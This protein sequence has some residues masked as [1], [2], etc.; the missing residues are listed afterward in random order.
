MKLKQKRI[1]VLDLRISVCIYD[2]KMESNYL[3]FK[4]Y[5]F[6]LFRFKVSSIYQSNIIIQP[7]Y[8]TSFHWLLLIHSLQ[9][10]S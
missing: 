2:N 1:L 3:I 5:I 8:N 4:L 10:P 9:E 6:K 7:L